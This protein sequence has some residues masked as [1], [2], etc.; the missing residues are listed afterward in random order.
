MKGYME[1]KCLNTSYLAA[2]GTMLPATYYYMHY[3]HVLL[4]FSLIRNGD[5][6][7]Y[8]FVLLHLLAMFILHGV[9]NVLF[10]SAGRIRELSLHIK[11]LLGGNVSNLIK[12]DAGFCP[13]ISTDIGA[14]V[15]VNKNTI[16]VYYSNLAANVIELLLI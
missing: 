1:L 15:L 6:Y 12:R 7:Q 11:T 2:Y 5:H 16:I 4:H 3:T 14:Y 8:Q 13:V 9:V 10:P